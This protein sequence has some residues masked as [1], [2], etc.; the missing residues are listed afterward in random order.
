MSNLHAPSASS[1]RLF[2]WQL[3]LTVGLTFLVLI[4]SLSS[5]VKSARAGSSNKKKNEVTTDLPCTKAAE[6]DVDVVF[7]RMSG[8]G[9]GSRSFPLTENE[10]S[11]YCK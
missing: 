3:Q 4:L 8:Y 5:T 2:L 9:N 1:T 7:G 11:T 10:L 6:G